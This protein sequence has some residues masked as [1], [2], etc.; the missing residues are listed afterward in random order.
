[1]DEF[2]RGQDA[3]Y[4][5]PGLF[6]CAPG[7]SQVSI[8]E[9]AEKMHRTWAVMVMSLLIVNAVQIL[10]YIFFLTYGHVLPINQSI[11]TL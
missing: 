10:E 9:R 11:V 1:M 2:Q 5:H 4:K 3:E 6:V 8:I 7:R